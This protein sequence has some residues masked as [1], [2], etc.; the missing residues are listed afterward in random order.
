MENA[1]RY[2]GHTSESK[3]RFQTS[4]VDTETGEW[5]WA[6]RKLAVVGGHTLSL[7]FNNSKCMNENRMK[8]EYQEYKMELAQQQ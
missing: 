5:T 4:L 3:I 6:T 2:S 1:R 8:T 7:E